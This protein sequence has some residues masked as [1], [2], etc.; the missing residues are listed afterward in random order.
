MYFG[1][2]LGVEALLV[3]LVAVNQITAENCAPERG[4]SGHADG[5]CI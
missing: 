5:Q 4:K 3:V 2:R 1:C